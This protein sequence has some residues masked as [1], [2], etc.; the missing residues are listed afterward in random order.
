M[1]SGTGYA[2]T[3]HETSAADSRLDRIQRIADH[4]FRCLASD[5]IEQDPIALRRQ[6][7]D[8]DNPGHPMDEVGYIFRERDGRL[9][10]LE[11]LMPLRVCQISRRMRA[12]DL[13]VFVS[14]GLH[15]GPER[16]IP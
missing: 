12:A 3:V 5:L 7:R 14:N 11:Q 16:A 15:E 1:D 6:L 4:S 13:Q 9:L 8:A 2:D 10:G